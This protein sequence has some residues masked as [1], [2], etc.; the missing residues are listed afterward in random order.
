MTQ[1]VVVD[2]GQTCIFFEIFSRSVLDATHP[3]TPGKQKKSKPTH[4]VIDMSREF[5]LT[6]YICIGYITGWPD[7][8]SCS[9]FFWI[10]LKVVIC[11]I[12]TLVCQAFGFFFQYLDSENFLNIFAHTL[13]PLI[14]P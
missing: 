4:I 9:E 12:F 7:I 6:I 3:E 13:Q 1:H 14:N 11:N 10:H 5:F 8:I 2:I